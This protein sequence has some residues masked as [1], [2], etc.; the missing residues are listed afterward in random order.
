MI[1]PIRSALPCLLLLYVPGLAGCSEDAPRESPLSAPA[2]ANAPL[3]APAKAAAPNFDP[4]ALLGRWAATI[5]GGEDAPAVAA[6]VTYTTERFEFR[7]MP[8]GEKALGYSGVWRIEGDFLIETPE[9]SDLPFWTVGVPTRS[10]ILIL[11]PKQL[12]YERA[13][14]VMRFTR[15]KP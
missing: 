14:S 9:Q 1:I 5:E 15:S 8:E 4:A 6:E 12:V 13:D 3:P 2:P 10:R 7:L 11:D